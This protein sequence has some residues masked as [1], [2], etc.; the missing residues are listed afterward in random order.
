[1][2]DKHYYG[3]RSCNCLPKDDLGVKYFSS[4]KDN[5]FRDDQKTFPFKYKYKVV[6]I[7]ENREEAILIEIKLHNKFDVGINENFY[8]QAKQTSTGF[9]ITGKSHSPETLEKLK[10]CYKTFS[11]ESFDKMRYANKGKKFSTEHKQKISNSL[12]GRS[13]SRKH[14]LTL[15]NNRKGDSNP[16]FKG[17][18]IYRKVRY[19]SIKEICFLLSIPIYTAYTIFKNLDK[20]INNKSYSCNKFI[21]SL[22]NREE[23]VGKTFR[24]LE[25][26]YEQKS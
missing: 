9:D 24:N 7:F 1:V 6:R 18:Y 3:V 8:N 14:K 15:S 10:F 5:D 17:Y 2:L 23:I 26:E 4:S 16:N 13:F 22:G 20:I 21:Q 12:T 25:F 11:E 19:T